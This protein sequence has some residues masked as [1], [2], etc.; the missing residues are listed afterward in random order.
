[1]RKIDI[2]GKKFGRL[3]ALKRIGSNGSSAI[4]LCKC[5]CGNEK[6]VTLQHLKQGTKS[7]GCLHKEILS[8]VWTK[9]GK[10]SRKHGDFGTKLYGVWAAMKRRIL[11]KNSNYYSEYGGRGI[12]I[13]KE[14]L[15]YLPFKDWAINNG[16]QD[17]L[18]LDRIDVNG[19]YEPS[20]CRWV[21]W[22]TQHYNKRNT[23][24]IEYKGKKYNL[25]EISKI[26]GLNLRTIKGRYERGWTAEQIFC[27]QLKKNQ[28]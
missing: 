4:W 10:T 1:M 5:E 23:V 19:N 2:T 7:C 6:E 18:T 11:N 8:K 27:K 16:Y 21:T 14:W 20:N 17:G 13:C 25:K 28:Y 24:F 15:E 9:I 26:T 12:S 22:E 3:T